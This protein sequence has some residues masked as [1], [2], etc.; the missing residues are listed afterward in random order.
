[1]AKFD[2]EVDGGNFKKLYNKSYGEIFSE[3]SRHSMT[4]EHVH[5]LAISY[6]E[7]AESSAIKAAETAAFQGRVGESKVH[8]VR[9]FTWNGLRLFVGISDS[10]VTKWRKDEAY[11]PV[12]EFIDTVI[13]EQKFQLAAN[14]IINA[15]FIGKEMGIDKPATINVETSN[16][17]SAT[18]NDAAALKEAVNDVLN[19]L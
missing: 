19:M 3:T 2:P 7:W 16:N 9:V 8:K 6:F 10:V 12:I 1:M 5:K 15:G 18:V 14:G 11:A 4:P 13:Y 17:S